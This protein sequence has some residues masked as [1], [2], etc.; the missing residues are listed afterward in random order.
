MQENYGRDLDLNLLRVFVVVAEQGSVTQ[1]AA[2]LYLTQPAV[3]AA[4]RRLTAAVGVPLFV[5]QGRGLVLTARGA[6]LQARA[7][8][9]LAAL[10][11]AALA[12]AAFDPTTS[13][14]TL[15]LGLSDAAE[16]WLLPEILRVLA[17]DAPRM[18]VI[19]VPVN[20]RTVGEVITEQRLDA[21]I[22]V[23]DELAPAIRRE[24]LYRG[25]FVCLFDPGHA[26]VGRLTEVD[27]FAHDHVAVSYNGDL[28]G[29]VEDSLR[30]QRA[31]R[32][33]VSSF[34]SLGNLLAGS[35]LLATVPDL[36]AHHIRRVHPQLRIHP[37][38]FR[39]PSS[40][41]ELLW[42][43]ASDDDGPCR[44][45]RDRIRE[46]ARQASRALVPRPRRSR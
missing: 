15:R 16:L 8:A 19:A 40:A 36:V 7:Q 38:P 30:K 33:S 11:E 27:Y 37:L 22:T 20:F 45:A 24:R 42:P 31:I 18:R 28:R 44:F 4:L 10:V 14:R 23:A 34:A 5:R 26:R 43:G 21:A 41:S 46:I 1:A 9:H 32:C 3:S 29:I 35:P 12:P 17:R 13:E 39:L 6:L 2:R 25:G